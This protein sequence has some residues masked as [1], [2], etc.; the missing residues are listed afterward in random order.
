MKRSVLSALVLA[1]VFCLATAGAVSAATKVTLWTFIPQHARFFDVMAEKWNAQHPDRQIELESS[2]LPYDDMHNKLQIALQSGV[3]APDICDIEISRFPNF[4]MGVPQLLPLNDYFA[5]YLDDIVPSRLGI[6]S[7]GANMYGAPTHVGATV[8]F[9]YVELL[10]SAGIDYRQIKTWD[11]FAEAGRKL[12]QVHPDK[13]MGIAETSAA[14]TVTAMLAQQG[15]DLVSEDERPLIN[16]PEMLRAVT[17]MQNMVKEGIMTTCPD[18]QPDTEGGKGFID[19]G[20]VAC[21]IMPLWFMSRFV[22]EM[23]SMNGKIAIAPVPVFEEGMP[24]SLG[25]GGTGTVVTN[26]AVDKDLVGE[27]VA[28]AKLSEDANRMIWEDL[29]FDPCNTSLWTDR[30]M[31]HNPENRYNQYFLNNAFDVLLEI[32][33]EIQMVRSTSISPTINQYLTTVMLNELFEDLLD[34]AEVIEQAQY[35]I[36]NQIF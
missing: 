31:T 21:V 15:T 4:L 6:Y 22:D 2:V 7:K 35:D 30:E 11:D 32:K 20:N 18:G 36:E 5:P 8:A 19:Q 10:E 33:D 26:Y 25:L 34:P 23:P 12:K 28:Y 13:F 9:Y 3:G 27:F 1:L 16:T 29:G 24:R 17:T 14:W